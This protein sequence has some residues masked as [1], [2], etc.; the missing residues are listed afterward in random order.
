M[1]EFNP[2]K[3]LEAA[4]LRGNR[5]AQ[6]VASQVQLGQA[7]EAAQ[8]GRDRPAQRVG[9]QV[10]PFQ[11][12]Q[13]PE[14]GGDGAAQAVVEQREATQVV[15]SAQFG[16]DRP[17]QLVVAEA[18][19]VQAGEGPQ[20]DRERATDLVL[21]EGQLGQTD[22]AAQLSRERSRQPVLP[23]IQA[24]D[25]VVVVREDAV[26]LSDRLLGQ[27]VR[28]VV[29]VCSV[30]GF[31]E[32]DQ[33]GPVRAGGEHANR[34]ERQPGLGHV[35]VG[36]APQ[37]RWDA[38]D[39]PGV[40]QVEGFQIREVRELVRDQP[41]QMGRG[42]IQ[43][44]KVRQATQ[45]SRHWPVQREVGREIEELEVRKVT[46]CRRERALQ[47][48]VPEFELLQPREPAEFGR[49]R[50]RQIV[51]REREYHNSARAVGVDSVPL[52]ERLVGQPVPAVKPVRAVRRMVERDEGGAV[53][54]RG[55][56]G[57]QR[58]GERRARQPAPHP[59]GCRE[60]PRPRQQPLPPLPIRAA[61]LRRELHASVG[62]QP[63]GDAHLGL[64]RPVGP[65][66]R[67]R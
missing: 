60:E 13:S 37:V 48:V 2:L 24:H 33:R 45:L 40:I 49:K 26:P 25:P 58:H 62:E 27:P 34:A 54:G 5:T 59:G 31:V 22:Q 63:R 50:P 30:G 10:Q 36:H 20:L 3:A 4:E 44:A 52:A 12:S 66:H 9:L 29:P 67:E 35:Y 1:N 64:S 51:P 38:P 39:Q 55:A 15:E 53:Q 28:V 11:M 7:G 47:Q 17:G 16:R 18:Q 23:E 57:G 65:A 56:R 43:D 32:G 61:L 6:V 14:L 21:R 46:Q 41:A 8:L 19:R 42:Q